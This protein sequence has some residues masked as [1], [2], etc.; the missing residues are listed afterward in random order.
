LRKKNVYT[1]PKH[2][3]KLKPEPGPTPKARP[4]LQIWAASAVFQVFSMSRWGIEPSLLVL[5]ARAT[6]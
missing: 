4:D 2:F 6:T 3:D 5:V 1:G